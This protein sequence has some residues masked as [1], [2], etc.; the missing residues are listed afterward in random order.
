MGAERGNFYDVDHRDCDVGAVPCFRHF[1]IS[2]RRG[3]LDD[4]GRN[5]FKESRRRERG[6]I[7]RVCY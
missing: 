5:Y 7:K 6:K 2:R 4:T 1:D 3:L